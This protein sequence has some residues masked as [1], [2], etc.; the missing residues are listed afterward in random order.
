MDVVKDIV[1]KKVP[2]V[3]YSM[4]KNDLRILN[5]FLACDGERSVRTIARE[6]AYDIENLFEDIDKMKKMGLLIPADGTETDEDV[7]IS[8][9]GSFCNLPKGF[10]TGI[11]A[12]DGQH[13]RLVDM[14]N[15][16]DDV[17]K[18]PYKTGDDKKTAVGEIVSEMVDYTI[19]HFAFEESLMED[20]GYKF[21]NAHKRVHELLVQRAGE[22]KE[23]WSSGEDIAD[24]LYEVLHR[25]LFNHIR[26]DDK[27]YAS[28]ILRRMKEL[29]KSNGN[30]LSKLVKRFFK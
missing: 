3:E 9:D 23:R 17:R 25:W 19:S 12:V 1:F 22:Y 27:A 5:I 7:Q 2:G 13:Q 29:D 24:E 8:T 15:Q 18:A 10:R 21:Y 16:L 30:W 6:D 28:A 20:A 4:I 26:N 11:D 14:V